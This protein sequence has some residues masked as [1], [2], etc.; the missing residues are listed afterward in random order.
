MHAAE[1]R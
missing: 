1:T